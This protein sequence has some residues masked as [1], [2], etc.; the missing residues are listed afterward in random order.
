MA[1]ARHYIMF[2]T[3]HN[4]YMPLRNSSLLNVK[5]YLFLSS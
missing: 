2:K 4:Q 5:F 1:L 3:V